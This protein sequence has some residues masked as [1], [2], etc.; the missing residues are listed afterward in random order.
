MRR[1]SGM[2]IVTM[3]AILAIGYLLV[4]PLVTQLLASL[5]GPYLPIGVPSATVSPRWTARTAA[6][7]S[8]APATWAPC[9]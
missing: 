4:V 5:R 9:S 2:T 7:I 8:A 6:A 1:L 3:V